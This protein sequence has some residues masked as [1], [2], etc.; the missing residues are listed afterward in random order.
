[1]D[2]LDFLGMISPFGNLGKADG[3]KS[4]MMA[5]PASDEYTPTYISESS[6]AL[7]DSCFCDD[8]GIWFESEED[9]VTNT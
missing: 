4:L 1:M 7:Y 9:S 2:I 3:R 6:H 8:L 5:L